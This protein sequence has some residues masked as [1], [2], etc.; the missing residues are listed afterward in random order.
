MNY[1]VRWFDHDGF[2]Q[3]TWN[4]QTQKTYPDLY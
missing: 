4:K 3:E 1:S 2:E